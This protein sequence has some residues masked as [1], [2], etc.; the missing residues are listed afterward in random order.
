MSL[1]SSS[2]KESK[3]CRLLPDKSDTDIV[4]KVVSVQYNRDALH[5][6]AN[7]SQTPMLLII[8][9]TPEPSMPERLI[10]RSFTSLQNKYPKLKCTSIA[11]ALVKPE[12]I[13]CVADVL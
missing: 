3:L 12:I 7:P 4:S 13:E 5:S 9:V 10:F 6:T 2:P 8:T 11:T 1:G